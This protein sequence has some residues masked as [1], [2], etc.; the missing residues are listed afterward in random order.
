MSVWRIITLLLLVGCSRTAEA[1]GRAANEPKP[2]AN[3]G[4]TQKAEVTPALAQ[5]A[6][7]ILRANEGAAIGAEIPFTLEG[8]RYVA[9]I[10]EHDNSGGD[11]GHPSGK[12]KGVTVYVA[13]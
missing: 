3:K 2:E 4:P 9:R 10:E 1:E 7:G 8:R 11:P 12:H 6:E 13:P 5:K